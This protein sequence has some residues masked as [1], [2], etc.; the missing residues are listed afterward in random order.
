MILMT[1]RPLLVVIVCVVL[2]AADAGGA[3]TATTAAAL[4]K[5]VAS[6]TERMRRFWGVSSPSLGGKLRAD[7]GFSAG[8]PEASPRG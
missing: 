6:V 2:V 4:S 8:K 7:G 1:T 5:A 3:I